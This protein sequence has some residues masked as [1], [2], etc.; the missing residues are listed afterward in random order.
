[1]IKNKDPIK[2]IDL[3]GLDFKV[4]KSGIKKNRADLK[5]QLSLGRVNIRRQAG[6]ITIQQA[7]DDEEL[8]LIHI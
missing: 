2:K 4:F 1:M 3:D 6:K 5:K 7:Y 8:S